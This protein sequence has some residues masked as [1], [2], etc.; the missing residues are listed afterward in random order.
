MNLSQLEVLVAIVDAGS[1]SEAAETVSLTQSAVSYSLSRLE[2]ELGVT[3]LE[4]GRQGITVTRIGEEVVRHARRI[5]SEVEIIRQKT[6]REQGFTTGK[7]R[8]GCVP[9]IPPRL[10]TGILRSFQQKYPDL[11]IVVFEGHPTELLRWL[12]EGTVDV[13][14]VPARH[15]FPLVVP[16]VHTNLFALFA[17]GHPLAQTAALADGLPLD[18]L[19][20]ESFIGPADEYG[21]LY[22]MLKQQNRTLPRLR[23]AVSSLSTILAM[24]REN[25]GVALMLELLIEPKLMDGIVMCPL[26]PPLAV[27]IFLAARVVSPVN[28]IFIHNAADWAREHQ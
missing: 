11:D 15:D 8:F 28:D 23:Y 27:E 12:D 18:R 24:V 20:G 14:T 22:Q 9:T 5:L 10:L 16:F 26:L 1:L 6:A 2:T 4:R 25:M 7:L 17:E 3:L 13:A 19:T 21:I